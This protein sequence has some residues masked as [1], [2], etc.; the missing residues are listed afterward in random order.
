MDDTQNTPFIFYLTLEENLPRTFYTFSKS[1]RD[2]GYM[3]VPV[4]I[5]QLQTLIATAE[6]SQ[7][8]VIASVTSYHELK[9]YNDKIRGLLRYVLKSKR[10][11]FMLLS[12]FSKINDNK[13]HS[14]RKN[15]YFLKYPVDAYLLSSTPLARAVRI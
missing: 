7:I 6:Q 12:S 8:V 3:L 2:L 4:K 11:T 13:I 14:L 15:Y 10:M 9:L 5:D 1:M